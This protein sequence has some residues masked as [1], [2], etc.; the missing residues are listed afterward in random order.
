MTAASP[1]SW[2]PISTSLPAGPARPFTPACIRFTERNSVP[3]ICKISRPSPACRRRRRP[4]CSIFGSSRNSAARRIC[5]SAN[6]P[7]PK[8]FS[9]AT[10]RTC[11]SIQRSAG[12]SCRR[13]ICRAADRTGRKARSARVRNG[14]RV[15]RSLCARRSST[16]ILPAPA[17]AI[18]CCAIPMD[19][20]FAST[21]RRSSSPSSSMRL[22][23]RS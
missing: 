21:I 18:R 3:P 15:A 8:N 16:A 7:R 6:S 13:R 1:R 12:R 17:P 22:Q 19:L 9:S 5:A 10:S 23:S 11:S 14:R 20:P 2:M 4:V